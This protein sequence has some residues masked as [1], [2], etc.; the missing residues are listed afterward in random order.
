[1]KNLKNTL[2]VFLL[3][4]SVNAFSQSNNPKLEQAL[5]KGIDLIA[6]AK[7]SE[8]FLKSANY[9]ERIA[10][11]ETKAWIPHYYAAY[12]SLM[13]GVENT[14]RN[15]KDQLWDKGLVEI[16]QADK[17]SPENSEI[18]ALKGY[19]E[20]MKLSIDPQSRLQYM[21]QSAASLAQAKKLNPENPRIY[22]VSGQN[23]FYTPEAFGGGKKNA[24]PLLEAAAAKFA[25]FKTDSP[26]MPNWGEDRLKFLLAQC[27]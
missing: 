22:L 27:N 9:F 19:L 15:I 12:S 4:F 8:D 13:A 3:V 25:I 14:D 23:T 18:F 10:Q 11:V 16:E 26:L 6:A 24:K 7:G 21:G 5:T 17:L 2:T 20:Y 1:M